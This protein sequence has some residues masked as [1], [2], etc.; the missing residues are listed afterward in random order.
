LD[1]HDYESKYNGD[2]CP[3]ESNHLLACALIEKKTSL[4]FLVTIDVRIFRTPGN[5]ATELAMKS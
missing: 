1:K 5:G 2:H 4:T 3:N